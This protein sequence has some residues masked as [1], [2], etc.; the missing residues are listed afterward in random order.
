MMREALE[1]L[2]ERFAFHTSARFDLLA[3]DHVPYADLSPRDVEGTLRRAIERAE[4]VV[5][6]TGRMGA[7]KSSVIAS[8]TN[9]LDEGFVPLRVS[10][11]DAEA[12]S[13]TAFA[14]HAIVE[15]SMLPQTELGKH[16]RLALERATAERRMVDRV[17]E[18]RAGFSIRGGHVLTAGVTADLKAAARY[19]LDHAS[20]PADVLSG[21]Q[22][23][24]DEF[25]KL[26]RCPVLIVDDTD[27][28]GG[29][30]DVADA[31]FDQT[32]RAL[33][34]LDAVV[35][36]ATQ[37]GYTQLDGYQ[38]IRQ[39]FTAEIELPALSNAEDGC[40]R[41]M[42]R[43]VHNEVPDVSAVDLFDPAAFRLVVSSY[44]E[45]V[46]AGRAGDVRRMLAVV[47]NALEL[48]LEDATSER[49]AVGHVQEAMAGNPVV[50]SP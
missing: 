33:G 45:S 20:D 48:A 29:A 5:A 40:R 8:V 26:G 46:S 9:D 32:A 23:L 49:I 37:T 34:R 28:W 14:R 4:G 7:G 18:L 3:I 1:L 50:A 13:P 24:F 2:A 25:W 43:R 44:T 22:R 11:V 27:H 6:V 39:A 35:V 17:R 10:V 30:L 19:Q 42:Q 36:V 16:E 12:G 38:R 41:I 21:L 47:R 31:F 15:I